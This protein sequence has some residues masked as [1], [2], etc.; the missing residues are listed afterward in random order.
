MSFHKSIESCLEHEYM[1]YVYNIALTVMKHWTQLEN[2]G[3]SVL[4]PGP[5]AKAYHEK[6]DCSEHVPFYSLLFSIPTIL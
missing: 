2:A 4:P 1:A 3:M 6:R 5:K